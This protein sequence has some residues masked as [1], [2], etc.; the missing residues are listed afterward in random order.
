MHMLAQTLRQRFAASS[1]RRHIELPL[2][3]VQGCAQA[4]RRGRG[5]VSQGLQLRRRVAFDGVPLFIS[6]R[7]KACA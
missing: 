2:K 1:G 3:A 4:L 6:G 5:G 7:H